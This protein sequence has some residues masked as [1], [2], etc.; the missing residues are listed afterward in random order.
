MEQIKVEHVIC[1]K[2]KLMKRAQQLVFLYIIY[3]TYDIQVAK[4]NFILPKGINIMRNHENIGS[5]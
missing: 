2:K 5:K 3:I 4:A 1:F